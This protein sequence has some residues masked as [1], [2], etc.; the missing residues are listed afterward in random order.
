[1]RTKTGSGLYSERGHHLFWLCTVSRNFDSMGAHC[2]NFVCEQRE[3]LHK[4]CS[5]CHNDVLFKAGCNN[6]GMKRCEN[7]FRLYTISIVLGAR[8]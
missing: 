2:T 3:E 1:M 8:G 7:R 4:A 6:D 5:Q